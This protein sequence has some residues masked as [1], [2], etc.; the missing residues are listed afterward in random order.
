M[1]SRTF[2]V[3]IVILSISRGVMRRR[4][5]RKTVITGHRLKRES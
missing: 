5:G 2:T 3:G 1:I 4:K